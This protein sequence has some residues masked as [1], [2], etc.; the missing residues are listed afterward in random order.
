MNIRY[1]LL[2]ALLL[3]LSAFS[4]A[5]DGEEEAGALKP[6]NGLEYKAEVQATVSDGT[7]PLWL[8]ANRYGLSSLDD[9]NGYV[10]GSLIRPLRN[11]S[12][13]H[14]GIGYGADVAVATGFTSTLVV[15]QAFV[16]ARWL[17][18]VLTVG[19]K[20]RL[21]QMKNPY[22]SSGAQTLGINARPIPQVWAGLPDYWVVPRTKGWL[23]LKGHLAYG[24]TT[25]DSWQQDFTHQLQRYT[26][27][28][29]YH[30]KA[31]YFKVGNEERYFPLSFEIG[32]EMACQFGGKSYQPDGSVIENESGAKSV[33]NALFPGGSDATDGN[34]KNAEGNHL[35][36]YV[37]RLNYDE[38]TW[39]LGFY[40]DQ[41][42]EDNSM[43]VHIANNG[44]GEGADA[45][46]IVKHRYFL[47]DFKDWMLG[48]EF[49]LKYNH[50]VNGVVLE[51][52]TTKYQG[53]PTYHDHTVNLAEHYTG[54]DN[55][56]NH[57]I[58]TGWQHWGQVIGNPLYR[59]PL[60]NS[61]GRIVVEDNRF[62]A[63]HLGLSGQPSD[64]L[65]YRLLATYRKGFGS[66]YNVYP[67]P[68]KS[69]NLMAE[70]TWHFPEESRLQGWSIRGAVGMDSGKWLGNNYGAQ[71]TVI[72]QGTLGRKK[73][74]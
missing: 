45:N 56:Y 67:K 6:F 55:Y 23:R 68:L 18:A 29:L 10:R 4:Q 22:L 1:T 35:G 28:T 8:N 74:K 21:P 73:R 39:A 43:M 9:V 24:I 7:T 51:Y 66:Y 41:F 33:V 5:L 40:V 37:A 30:S 61:D 16:E 48:A 34:Y 11:D 27:N 13:R 3:P 50:L 70:A 32:L 25:D 14:W 59:S 54:L 31:I 47:Y 64:L 65:G 71:L 20:E 38:E 58:F 52:L 57:H 2:S 60:Y 15:Q 63:I 17:H 69:F 36:S 19:S 44:W 72:K 49:R 46:R 26:E 12:L 42:F 62:Q 53:G